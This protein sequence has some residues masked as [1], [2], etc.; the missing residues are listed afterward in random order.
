MSKN[1]I[2]E[3]AELVKLPEED[4]NTL[5]NIVKENPDAF[6]VL[7]GAGVSR[8][9]GILMACEIIDALL[10]DLYK[11]DV[12]EMKG[13]H[14]K[15]PTREQ[16][17]ASEKWIQ[18][19][20]NLYSDVLERRFPSQGQR[21]KYFKRLIKGKKPTPGHRYIANIATHGYFTVTFTPNFDK[22]AERA[23][24][25][26]GVDPF[27]VSHDRDAKGAPS[28]SAL[29]KI[30]KLHGDYLY[31]NLQNLGSETRKLRKNMKDKFQNF[32]LNRGL[33]VVGYA[34]NDDSILGP[35]EKLASEDA[36]LNFGIL[37]VL[38][39]GEKPNNR[40]ANLIN[41]SYMKGSRFVFVE[42]SD[43]FFAAL[44]SELGLED[45]I[46]E[47]RLKFFG[48]SI[49]EQ[50]YEERGYK[51][52]SPLITTPILT[53]SEVKKCFVATP[54][55]QDF[56]QE[57][58]KKDLC[59][60]FLLLS[61]ESTGK[62]SLL[63]FLGF[64]LKHKLKK[65]RVF[66]LREVPANP[67][68]D[69]LLEYLDD[70]FGV[71][72]AKIPDCLLIFDDIH[73]D[74]NKPAL[75]T[76][77]VSHTPEITI[78]AAGR[79]EQF[80]NVRHIWEKIKGFT[81]YTLP[82]YL[83]KDKKGFRLFLQKKFRSLNATEKRLLLSRS[84]VTPFH[85]TRLH[86]SL[87]N[88]KVD[89]RKAIAEFTKDMKAVFDKTSKELASQEQFS[90]KIISF[91][92]SLYEP[93]LDSFLASQGYKSAEIING[94]VRKTFLHRSTV[95]KYLGYQFQIVKVL[96]VKDTT[97]E[98]FSRRP[99]AL[100]VGLFLNFVFQRVQKEDELVRHLILETL[101]RFLTKKL[102]DGLRSRVSEVLE[103]FGP[104]VTCRR[105]NITIDRSYKYCPTCGVNLA[106]Q[107]KEILC[108]IHN[109]DKDLCKTYNELCS[110]GF[111]A[112]VPFPDTYFAKKVK[113][114][115]FDMDEIK[116]PE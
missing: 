57:R 112:E 101:E 28:N 103:E 4:V 76:S 79:K 38:R 96:S 102:P 55:I 71:P 106:T 73:A 99:R 6:A 60:N 22:L 40:V 105:C 64:R 81:T 113:K 84:K 54:K 9:A 111:C 19:S 116:I 23:V 45:P 56:C 92:G 110:K 68:A 80:E 61:P 52:N 93:L 15:I 89:R 11:R 5:A 35:L 62:T 109:P 94:L 107:R 47:E 46:E 59:E 58:E 39:H 30:L 100:E 17:M 51:V 85:L 29:I 8:S 88:R 86:F 41:N 104:H 36:F 13:R 7:I 53:G 95:Q 91:L 32:L 3:G 34:G 16:W 70:C 1:R 10:T 98:I 83:D 20:T 67:A 31:S 114:P 72:S 37:W 97:K 77:L 25:R 33:I 63:S 115:Q 82:D 44:N 69:R 2:L 108:P 75:I 87:R 74:K 50:S 66:W 65:V 49:D 42:D 21:E 24:G 14:A 78:W 90:L 43:S 26:T 18:T 12:K 27:V 48:W